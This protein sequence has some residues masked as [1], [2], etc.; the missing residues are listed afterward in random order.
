V[1]LIVERLRLQSS[2]A[3]LRRWCSCA[4]VVAHDLPR[5]GARAIVRLR[6]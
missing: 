2:P 1:P 4:H 6:A 3:A 5:N